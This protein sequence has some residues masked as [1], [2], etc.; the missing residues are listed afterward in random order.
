MIEECCKNNINEFSDP[1]S[2]IKC[3][4]LFVLVSN[5]NKV[6]TRFSTQLLNK[7]LFNNTPISRSR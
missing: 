6:R 3:S 7:I 5:T 2:I 1:D 4:N